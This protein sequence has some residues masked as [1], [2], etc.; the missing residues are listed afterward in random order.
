M[1]YLP[2]AVLLILTIT[3]GACASSTV[4]SPASHNFAENASVSLAPDLQ[5]ETLLLVSLDDGSVIMQ[6]I[7]SSADVCFK[8]N[9]ASRT[10]CLTQGAPVI[11]PETNAVIGFEMFEDHIDLVAKS[12]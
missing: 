6:T 7:Y 2:A 9:S 12:N 5:R 4:K 10:T 11:D 1:N 8:V 3:L